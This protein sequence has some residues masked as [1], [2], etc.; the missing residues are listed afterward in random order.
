MFVVSHLAYHYSE[1]RIDS[2][3]TQSNRAGFRRDQRGSCAA[4]AS[5]ILSAAER[6]HLQRSP[7][8]ISFLPVI[9]DGMVVR[10][11]G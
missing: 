2:A 1:V 10:V 6:R 8:A 11:V 5:Q 3:A 4:L 7:T 9:V